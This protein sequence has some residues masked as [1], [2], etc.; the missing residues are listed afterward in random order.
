[1]RATILA[2][3]SCF[4]QVSMDAADKRRLYRSSQSLPAIKV[5]GQF[6]EK[7]FRLKLGP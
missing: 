4:G 7:L 2:R 1:M 5:A 6:L 3:K